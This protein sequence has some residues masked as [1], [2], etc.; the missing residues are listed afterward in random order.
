MGDFNAKHSH[1]MATKAGG[2]KGTQFC[3]GPLPP[4]SSWVILF[5][6]LRFLL[7]LDIRKSI[8]FATSFCFH[9]VRFGFCK[10]DI[11]SLFS[12]PSFLQSGGGGSRRAGSGRKWPRAIEQPP[13]DNFLENSCGGWRDKSMNESHCSFLCSLLILFPLSIRAPTGPR[14]RLLCMIWIITNHD[15]KCDQLSLCILEFSF[16]ICSPIL[17][18]QLW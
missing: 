16:Q 10:Q 8:E 15:N 11:V 6:L 18:D 1:T 3:Q 12:F 17:H 13:S 9:P 5:F 2:K 4:S 14:L 7:H